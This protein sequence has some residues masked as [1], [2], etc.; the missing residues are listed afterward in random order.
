M[1]GFPLL[2]SPALLSA[3]IFSREK[4]RLNLQNFKINFAG[5]P[6]SKFVCDL[7]KSWFMRKIHLNVLWAN[8]YK[9]QKV[10]LANCNT[11]KLL[12]RQNVLQANVF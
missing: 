10:I 3:A 8:C 1:E 9:G 7:R 5:F 6:V 2:D 11:V 12:V 4:I